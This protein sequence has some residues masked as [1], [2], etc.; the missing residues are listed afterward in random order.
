MFDLVINE[1]AKFVPGLSVQAV[2]VGAVEIGERRR[3][4]TGSPWIELLAIYHGSRR[5][6][7]LGDPS[8]GARQSG[9]PDDANL[10]L[11]KSVSA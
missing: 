2:D 7:R 8:R 9:D 3:R 4:Q 6:D 11:S 1:L 5:D 10:R